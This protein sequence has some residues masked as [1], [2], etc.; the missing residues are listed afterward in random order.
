M[1]ETTFRD[2]RIHY[3]DEGKGETLLLLH[4]F[5]E[6]SEIWDDFRGALSKRFRVITPDLLG[7]GKSSPPAVRNNNGEYVN[8]MEMQAESAAAVLK[9]AG[10]ERCT[11]VGHSMGG[12][13]ALAFAELFPEKV[14]GLCLF[15]S[16]AMADPEEKKRDRDK[17]IEAVKKDKKAFLEGLIPKMFAPANVIKMKGQ[18]EKVLDSAMNIHEDGLVAALAGMR[19]RK[20][21]QHV[22]EG[23][24]YPVLFI[25]GKDDLLIPPDRMLPLILKPGHAEAL[26]LSGVGHMGFYEAR[27]KTLFAIEKFMEET[28]IY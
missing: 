5:C 24:K 12:Y 11:V 21:R 14:K 22:L 19:D 8:T 3:R 25:I 4:G 23:A 10:V 26:L 27:E 1:K 6:S 17:A 20:D 9:S 2:F 28:V 16:T 13:T 18:V 15:H 7:H